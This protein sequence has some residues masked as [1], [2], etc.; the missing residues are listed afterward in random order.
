MQHAPLYRLKAKTANARVGEQNSEGLQRA[1][2]ALMQDHPAEAEEHHGDFW[3]GFAED[4]EHH[5]R[6]AMKLAEVVR[7]V[8]VVKKV[9]GRTVPNSTHYIQTT[10]K[11]SSRPIK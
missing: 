1:A 11:Q 7:S 5:S 9:A 6:R 2:A 8:K 4:L 10:T 3:E